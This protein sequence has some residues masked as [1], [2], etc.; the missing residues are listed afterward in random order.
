MGRKLSRQFEERLG[1]LP[2]EIQRNPVPLLVEE[3]IG[4]GHM[5]ACEI[6]LLLYQQALNVCLALA[7]LGV[8]LDDESRR[9]DRLPLVD[10]GNESRRI[11]V[12]L[13]EFQLGNTLQ[14]LPGRLDLRRIETGDLDKDPLG[15][16]GCDDGFTDTELVDTL[17]DDLDSLL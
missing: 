9:Q 12:D 10:P 6:R 16:L 1:S 17:A 13:G 14:L 8:L 3:C 7:G 2:I 11:G 15:A 5:L 4:M